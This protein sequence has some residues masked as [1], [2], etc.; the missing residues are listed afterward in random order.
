MKEILA[1]IDNYNY[2]PPGEKTQLYKE[3]I[4][5]LSELESLKFEIQLEKSIEKV[6]SCA[7]QMIS[8]NDIN[9]VVETLFLELSNLKIDIIRCGIGILSREERKTKTWSTTF[10]EENET[11]KISGYMSVDIHQLLSK[12]YD[13]WLSKES[14]FHYTLEQSDLVDYY[15]KLNHVNFNLQQSSITNNK[16]LNE[17]QYYLA[18]PFDEGCLFAFSKSDFLEIHINILKRFTQAFAIAYKRFCDINTA[19]ESTQR[20]SF[21]LN[22][23]KSSISYTER[24]Q[25]A[26]LPSKST[27]D[28]QLS[29]YFLIYIPKDIVSGDFILTKLNDTKEFLCVVGDCTGHGVPGAIMSV[30]LIT[31]LEKS[32]ELYNKPCEIFE[33]TRNQIIERLNLDGSIDGGKDG[34]DASIFILNKENNLLTY[35]TANSPIWIA[36]KYNNEEVE[37]IELVTNKMPVA[38]HDRDN[39]KFSQETIQLIKGDIIYCFTDGFKD[40]FGGAYNKKF[41]STQFKNLLKSINGLNMNEQKNKLNDEFNNWKKDLDQTDDICILGI[42]I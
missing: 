25:R 5:L 21:L 9:A 13:S 41:K 24:I 30:I 27:L 19:E 11:I 22:E 29:D 8:S 1:S 38:K 2:L 18:I 42:R 6:R 3:A 20:I 32:L 7:L 17:K 10:S 40:Q 4:E 16:E 23:I 33:H 31:A 12:A 35:T 36:R 37:I 34:M 39:V 26:F 28:E 15:N 14:C